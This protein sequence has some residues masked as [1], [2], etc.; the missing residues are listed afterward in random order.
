MLTRAQ[1]LNYFYSVYTLPVRN[2]SIW[3]IEN[4]RLLTCIRTFYRAY[5]VYP[6]LV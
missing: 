3:P 2:L 4:L 5:L 1:T 6:E